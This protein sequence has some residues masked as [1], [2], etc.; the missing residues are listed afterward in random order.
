MAI[1]GYIHYIEYA[2]IHNTAIIESLLETYPFN[3][4]DHSFRRRNYFRDKSPYGCCLYGYL[5]INFIV[6]LSAD[7]YHKKPL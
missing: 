5:R 4:V 2:Q 1:V 7:F 3:K 6:G